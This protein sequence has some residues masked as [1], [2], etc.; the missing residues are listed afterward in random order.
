MA[1]TNR[2]G[3]HYNTDITTG[4]YNLI[5]RANHQNTYIYTPSWP[6]T[7]KLRTR[8]KKYIVSGNFGGQTAGAYKPLTIDHSTGMVVEVESVDMLYNSNELTR[9]FALFYMGN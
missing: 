9:R 3:A 2:K 4:I 8:G 6:S 5:R 1:F 7:M